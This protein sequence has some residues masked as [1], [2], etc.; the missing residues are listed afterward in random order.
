[1]DPAGVGLGAGR[2]LG[3]PGFAPLAAVVLVK[4]SGFESG[5]GDEIGEFVE[6]QQIGFELAD[7]VGDKGPFLAFAVEEFSASPIGDGGRVALGP[8]TDVDADDPAI[9]A[10]CARVIGAAFSACFP[11]HESGFSK[12]RNRWGATQISR[13]GAGNHDSLHNGC[14]RSGADAVLRNEPRGR[15]S[16]ANERALHNLSGAPYPNG[17]L[18]KPRV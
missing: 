15:R 7:F 3:G 8:A 12:R 17:G 13:A 14:G 6:E 1:M 16:S 2:L 10:P 11:G 4:A 5:A 18:K 9:P